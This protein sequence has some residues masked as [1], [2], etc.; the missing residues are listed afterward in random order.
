MPFEQNGRIA[1][2]EHE[3]LS[4]AA[5]GIEASLFLSGQGCYL[6]FV[7][8]RFILSPALCGKNAICFLLQVGITHL[9]KRVD[10]RLV[11]GGNVFQQGGQT[12]GQALYDS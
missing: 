8:Q 1:L 7:E 11:F 12:V 9:Q 10:V 6:L 3:H 5:E 4:F 2:A